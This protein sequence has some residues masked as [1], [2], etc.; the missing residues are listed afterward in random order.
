VTRVLA[1]ETSLRNG[2]VAL[3][4]DGAIVAARILPTDSRSAQSL[5]PAVKE[6]LA[7]LGWKPNELSAVGVTIGPGS[8]TGVR[9]GVTFAKVFCY[10]ANVPVVGLTTL[11]VLAE[12]ATTE[13]CDQHVVLDAQRSDLFQQR[14]RVSANVAIPLTSPRVVS[15]EQWLRELAMEHSPRVTGAGLAKFRSV[16]PDGVRVCEERVWEPNAETLAVLAHRAI[17]SGRRDDVWKLAPLY[18][19]ASAAEEKRAGA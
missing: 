9:V 3:A 15:S 17:E 4:Q 6:M 7:A 2:S 16:L 13:D 5:A 18:L 10:A 14:F 1:I 12:Q 19:R 8:F 11:E